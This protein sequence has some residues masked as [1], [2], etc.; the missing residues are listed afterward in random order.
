MGSHFSLSV[1]YDVS[2]YEFVHVGT[3]KIE[4]YTGA[5]HAHVS[6]SNIAQLM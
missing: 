2:F 5:K 3:V 6:I 1:P 4:I